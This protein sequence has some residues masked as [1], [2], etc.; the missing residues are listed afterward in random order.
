M[1]WAPSVHCS[2]KSL[3][4]FSN[5]PILSGECH[6]LSAEWCSRTDCLLLNGKNHSALARCRSPPFRSARVS[7]DVDPND[8][9]AV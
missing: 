2:Q 4:S 3:P 7:Q 1:S 9:L 5:C 8:L 6:V